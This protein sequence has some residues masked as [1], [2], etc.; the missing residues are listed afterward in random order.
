VPRS[1]L[2]IGR[3]RRRRITELFEDADITLYD[4]KAAGR[5]KVRL[6]GLARRFGAGCAK[7]LAKIAVGWYAVLFWMIAI[8]RAT[9]DE[10][11]PYCF[12]VAL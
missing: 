5:N 12:A 6:F 8:W 2:L 4:A 9:V 3:Q 10:D 11:G 7:R 1:K